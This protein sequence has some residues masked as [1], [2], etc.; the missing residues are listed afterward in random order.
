MSRKIDKCAKT[1]TWKP[2]YQTGRRSPDPSG[3]H[4][5][6][7]RVIKSSSS[8]GGDIAATVYHVDGMDIVLEGTNT[9]SGVEEANSCHIYADDSGAI[10]IAPE[11]GGKLI[12]VNAGNDA[13]APGING[14]PFAA[15]TAIKDSVKNKKYFHSETVDVAFIHPP[16]AGTGNR[17]DRQIHG[18]GNGRT[19]SKSIGRQIKTALRCF[20][21]LSGLFDV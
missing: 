16:D 18:A 5:A 2:P 11:S 13:N 10:T 6:G 3:P 1:R 21:R 8:N 9:V 19:T 4:I 17:E 20:P 7:A 12:K 14:S 15:K